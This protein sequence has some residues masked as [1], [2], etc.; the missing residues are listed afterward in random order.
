VVFL[1]LGVGRLRYGVRLLVAP[2]FAILG[3]D[4][5]SVRCL[6]YCVV[7]V[8]WCGSRL[9]QDLLVGGQRGV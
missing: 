6:R 4:V 2:S 8:L 5:V 9:K 3:D 7:D 1:L